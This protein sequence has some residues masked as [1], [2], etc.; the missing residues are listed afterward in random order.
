MK[1]RR[2]DLLK[3]LS[4]GAPSLYQVIDVREIARQS[5]GFS[6]DDMF[7]LRKNTLFHAMVC[8]CEL[9]KRNN[10]NDFLVESLKGII[11]LQTDFTMALKSMS[12]KGRRRQELSRKRKP[13]DA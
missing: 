7:R 10:E 8:C 3:D 1:K 13:E 9:C 6:V 5:E 2:C 11:T 4:R 12:A